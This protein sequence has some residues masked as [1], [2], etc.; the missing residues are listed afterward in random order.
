M[1]VQEAVLWQKG[2]KDMF[3]LYSSGQ[4]YKGLTRRLTMQILSVVLSLDY[5]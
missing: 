4:F 2:G 1:A 5:D 3:L